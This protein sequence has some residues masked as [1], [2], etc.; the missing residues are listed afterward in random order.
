MVFGPQLAM[1]GENS[2]RSNPEVIMPMNKLASMMGDK[3][4]I[5][6][7]GRISGRDI[8]ISNRRNV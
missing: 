8:Q 5:E 2:S 4:K 3:M 7:V 6:V 1:V